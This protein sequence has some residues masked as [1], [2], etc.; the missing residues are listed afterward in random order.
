MRR[1][2]MGRVK[3]FPFVINLCGNFNCSQ[4]PRPVLSGAVLRKSGILDQLPHRLGDGFD[5]FE[6][7]DFLVD[8]FDFFRQDDSA[9][10]IAGARRRA[11][12]SCVRSL[13]IELAIVEQ[14]EFNLPAEL[15]GIRPGEE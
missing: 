9:I 8:A 2:A 13:E 15:R 5:A 11:V 1:I 4:L 10:E 3:L 14:G 12:S 7:E 6:I